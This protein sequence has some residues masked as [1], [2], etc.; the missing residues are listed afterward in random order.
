[1]RAALAP[2][3]RRAGRGRL[4]RSARH[5]HFA[6]RSDRV[7]GA[8]RRLR[9][10][11]R[12]LA[13]AARRLAQDQRR[14]HGIGGRHRRGRS[15]RLLTVQHGADPAAPALPRG[16]TPTSTSR[17]SRRRFRLADAW[18]AGYDR[19]LAAVS[20]FGSSGT[21]AHVILAG[22]SVAIG[23]G[24]RHRR[25]RCIGPAD[26][27]ED[28][29]RARRVDRALHSALGRA[30][31][32]EVAELCYTAAV[33]RS[34]FPRTA[35][36]VVGGR[37]RLAELFA[38]RSLSRR[39]CFDQSRVAMTARRSRPYTVGDR[40]AYLAGEM[41]TG[42]ACTAAGSVD[43]VDVP[44]YPFQR[45]RHW[46]DRQP[47]EVARSPQQ[48]SRLARRPRR[49][50]F[51][52]M[53]FNGTKRRGPSS[54]RMVLEAARFADAQRVLERLAARAALHR[55]RQPVSESGDDARRAGA[56]DTARA[57]DGRQRRAAAA[58]PDAGRRRVGG[59]RQPLGRPRRDVVRVRLE[60]R[61]LRAGSRSATRRGAT[62]C[63]AAS[64]RCGG[65]GAASG[66]RD[67][68][69]RSAPTSLCGRSRRRSS[70]SCRC[71]SPRRA[72]P[73]RSAGPAKSAHTC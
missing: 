65:C 13:A 45:E 5:R 66:F 55:L 28:R 20:S 41:S 30:V 31:D 33:G 21:I 64:R 59:R 37:L 52:M 69:R 38:V 16:R 63:S 39:R 73:R 11:G 25:R 60:S 9:R 54:Y 27:G 36:V 40:P 48:R 6:R 67:Q 15:R 72:I 42:A 3:R 1:M 47:A 24:G 61:R 57:A 58:Q 7:R 51:G 29:A 34:A 10:S 19:R 46:V 2:A 43:R 22:C 12:A 17:R 8:R 18:P 68:E 35:L 23:T 49:L 32:E 50:R 4:S 56:G 44:T 53:F 26:F 70:A 62:R 71:G 14:A